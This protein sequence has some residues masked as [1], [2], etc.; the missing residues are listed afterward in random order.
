MVPVAGLPDFFEPHI[1]VIDGWMISTL[2]GS[3]TLISHFRRN[4]ELTSF[5]NKNQFIFIWSKN[6]ILRS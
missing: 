5:E 2:L 6:N 4:S 3:Y 1:C